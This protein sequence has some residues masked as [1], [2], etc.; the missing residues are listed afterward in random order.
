[1]TYHARSFALGLSDLSLTMPPLAPAPTLFAGKPFPPRAGPGGA[2]GLAR[3]GE[4][5]MTTST[6]AAKC[7]VSDGLKAHMDALAER[8]ED[9]P[10][11]WSVPL[12]RPNKRRADFTYHLANKCRMLDVMFDLSITYSASSGGCPNE[13]GVLSLEHTAGNVNVSRRGQSPDALASLPNRRTTVEHD[14]PGPSYP[15]QSR[16]DPRAD[17]PLMLPL[18][19]YRVQVRGPQGPARQARLQEVRR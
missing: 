14:V 17:S 1:M 12:S 8:L 4:R 18:V 19:A 15:M 6:A 13:A 10:D 5:L 3:V 7:R 16:L 9:Q 11:K 2:S